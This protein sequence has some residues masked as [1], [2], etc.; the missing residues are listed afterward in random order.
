MPKGLSELKE[1]YAS[2]KAI[3]L[4]ATPT[5]L[6]EKDKLLYTEI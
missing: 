6:T 4:E 3:L 1:K 5:N 2:Q